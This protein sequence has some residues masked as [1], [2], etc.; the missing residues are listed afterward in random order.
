MYTITEH[1]FM[2]SGFRM[3]RDEHP[4]A[5]APHSHFILKNHEKWD[6]ARVKYNEEMEKRKKGSLH[7]SELST[8]QKQILTSLLQN[9]ATHDAVFSVLSKEDKEWAESLRYQAT[10]REAHDAHES[11]SEV[12]QVG[13]SYAKLESS[14]DG[15][16]SARDNGS[17]GSRATPDRSLVRTGAQTKS[18][19]KIH[20]ADEP[21]ECHHHSLY[22]HVR[23]CKCKQGRGSDDGD[24]DDLPEDYR[25]AFQLCKVLI[26]R[27]T[28]L[29]AQSRQMLV[30]SMDEDL[31]RTVLLADRNCKCHTHHPF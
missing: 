13:E 22:D 16:T 29:E 23:E 12:T 31:P 27:V 30:D 9:P 24:R 1:K 19:L 7:K 6:S 21:E 15:D 4:E 5:F 11:S 14:E 2:Q 17:S 26:D 3:A 25:L 10:T 20:T 28:H 8:K 18:K